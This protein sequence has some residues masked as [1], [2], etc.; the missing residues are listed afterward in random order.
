MNNIIKSS[1]FNSEYTAGGK[2]KKA[3]HQCDIRPSLAV[4]VGIEPT[5]SG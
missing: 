1:L 3:E 4:R 5:Q 2:M